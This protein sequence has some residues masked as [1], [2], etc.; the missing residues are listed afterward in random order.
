MRIQNSNPNKD[1][2]GNVIQGSVVLK[3]G[4]NNFLKSENIRIGIAR[5][6][7]VIGGGD[8]SNDRIIPDLMRSISKKKNLKIRNPK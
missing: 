5:A 8:W 2:N 7:N 6:G 1:Q 4:T 3:N